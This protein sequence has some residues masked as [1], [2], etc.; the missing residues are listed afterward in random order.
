M[1]GLAGSPDSGIEVPSILWLHYG[2]IIIC[3]QPVKNGIEEEFLFSKSPSLEVA[4]ITSIHQGTDY[5]AITKEGRKNKWCKQP[6]VSA[7]T[8]QIQ[9]LLQFSFRCAFWICGN[10]K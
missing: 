6:V 3:I 4:H 2:L 7:T 10:Y 5:T 9:S 8:T 1:F